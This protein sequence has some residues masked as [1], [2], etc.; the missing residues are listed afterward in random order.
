MSK[1][2]PLLQRL[3]ALIDADIAINSIPSPNFS[4]SEWQE[5]SR[6]LAM[7]RAAMQQALEA[8][9]LGRD[10]AEGERLENERR[11][12]GHE[13]LAP[14]DA[15]AL[16]QIDAAIAALRA[17]LAEQ[18]QPVEC[19]DNDSPWLICKP[20]ASSG[21]CAKE[22]AQPVAWQ[23]EIWYAADEVASYDWQHTAEALKALERLLHLSMKAPTPPAPQPLTERELEL[24]DGM[25]EVQLHHAAQCDLMLSRAGGNHTM[26]ERQKGWDMERVELLRKIKGMGVQR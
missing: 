10:Y 5:I 6:G 8:L 22:Q 18:T 26:A 12:K 20:C 23:D 19:T 24:I 7:S 16:G 21:K 25:I 4:F 17:A 9:E 15:Y 13:H 1:E 2:L 11:Y 3:K 14:D